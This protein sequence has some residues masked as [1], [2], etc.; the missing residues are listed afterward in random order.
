VFKVLAFLAGLGSAACGLLGIQEIVLILSGQVASPSDRLGL[1]IARL[2]F[3][4]SLGLV[5]FLLMRRR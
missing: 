2:G 3:S 4:V 1:T 5:A